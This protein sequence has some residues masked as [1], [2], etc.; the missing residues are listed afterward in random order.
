MS[1]D[2]EFKFWYKNYRGEVAKRRVRPLYIHFGKT[3]WH[4]T[5]QW[6]MC[7]FDL[8]KG[9]TR[10]FAMV[11]MMHRDVTSDMAP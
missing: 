11:D 5:E 2:Q 7:A 1:T 9:E 10:D 3:E 4:P 8:D 6:L